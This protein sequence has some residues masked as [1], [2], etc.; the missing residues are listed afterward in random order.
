MGRARNGDFYRDCSAYFGHLRR[1][2]RTD[3]GF[4]DEYY[5]T[6]PAISG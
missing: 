1:E 2:G 3:H 4:E 6:M 5:F